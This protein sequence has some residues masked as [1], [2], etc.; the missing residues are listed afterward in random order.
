MVRR[1]ISHFVLV[2]FFQASFRVSVFSIARGALEDNILNAL[3]KLRPLLLLYNKYGK[4]NPFPCFISGLM[5]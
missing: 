4:G 3:S 5:A 1:T 2:H